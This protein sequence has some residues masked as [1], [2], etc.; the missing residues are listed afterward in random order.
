MCHVCFLVAVLAQLD[1]RYYQ[2]LISKKEFI[3]TLQFEAKI[4]L[5]GQITAVE[6]RDSL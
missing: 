2:D 6:G 3:F 5:A 1:K 4:H